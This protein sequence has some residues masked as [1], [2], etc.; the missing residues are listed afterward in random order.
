MFA[1]T[2]ECA[3]AFVAQPSA[4]GWWYIGATRDAVQVRSRGQSPNGLV[5]HEIAMAFH[6]L[7]V[8]DLEQRIPH[9]ADHAPLVAGV[10]LAVVVVGHLPRPGAAGRT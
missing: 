7:D 1:A 4:P 10:D 2:R 6:V 3:R 5:A 9:A 8:T